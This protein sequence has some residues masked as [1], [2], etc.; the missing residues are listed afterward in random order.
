MINNPLLLSL[1]IIPSLLIFWYIYIKDKSEKEPFYLII[2]L[3]IG[4]IISCL[5]SILISIISK[6]YI[7]YLN[8]NYH[9][10]NI[11]E[12][13]FKVLVIIT[14]SEEITKWLINYITIWRN[15]NFKHIYDP[16]IYSTCTALGFATFENIIYVTNFQNHGIMVAVLRGIISIPSHAVFGIY[17]GYYLGIAKNAEAYNKQIKAIK[18]KILSILFPIILH[19]TFDILLVNIGTIKYSIFIIYL[20]VLYFTA[21]KKI[22]KLSYVSKPIKTTNQEFS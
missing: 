4:G 14:L 8:M 6:Q 5:I 3:F 20:A 2:L 9:N 13:I 21:L 1:C 11:F 15:K 12:I 7:P 18:Y 19:F 10:M 22:K 16:I 17:S